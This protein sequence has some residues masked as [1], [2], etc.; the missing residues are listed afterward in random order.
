M[1][2]HETVVVDNGSTDGTL[3]LV[4]ERF[5][6]VR[7]V[8]QE[9]RGMGGGNNAGMRVAAGRY[10]F[11]LN[12]D[13]WVVGDGLDRLVALRRRASGARPSSG[14]GS[15]NTDGSLQRSV[16]GEPTLW[17]LATEYLFLRKLAPRIAASER[18]LRRRLRPRRA[19]AR[20]SRST[21]A[22]LLVRREAADEVGLFDEASSCSARRPTG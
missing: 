9:N 5:P 1:R 4:R 12:S 16:R 14:R 22:A 21:G 2:G 17:R 18:V 7:V 15:R 13:A 20:S 19:C 3:E 10:F 8:E 11:L 6:D